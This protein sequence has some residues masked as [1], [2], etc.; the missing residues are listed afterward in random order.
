[1]KKSPALQ[2]GFL[3]QAQAPDCE[4]LIR[5]PYQYFATTGAGANQL[6]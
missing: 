5:V 1:M 2:P 3:E 6:K 4:R